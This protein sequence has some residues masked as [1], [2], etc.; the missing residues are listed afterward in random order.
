M[1]YKYFHGKIFE[2][3]IYYFDWFLLTWLECLL[4]GKELYAYFK[5]PLLFKTFPFM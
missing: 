5:G 1:L 4:A 2:I 3:M